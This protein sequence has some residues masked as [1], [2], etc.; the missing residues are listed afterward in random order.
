MRDLTIENEVLIEE[1]DEY[2]EKMDVIDKEREDYFNKLQTIE[3]AVKVNQIE[4]TPLG[5]ALLNIM[6]SG[7]EDTMRVDEENGD[8][9][10]TT[11]GQESRYQ[12]KQL[13]VEKV[14]EEEVTSKFSI[15]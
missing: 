9:I 11:D 6:Y 4:E 3:E 14:P 7:I 1:N 2:I 15:E 8:V 13:D 5:T 12:V 10:I